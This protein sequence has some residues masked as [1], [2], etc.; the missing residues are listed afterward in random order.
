M[1]GSGSP[2][3]IL[4]TIHGNNSSVDH[5][6]LIP[7][8]VFKAKFSDLLSAL[9]EA[10]RT[11]N[12]KG[13]HDYVV[14]HLKIGSAEC[15]LLERAFPTKK[16]APAS[17]VDALFQCANSIYRSNFG[18]ARRFNGVAEKLQKLLVGVESTFEY[19]ELTVPSAGSITCDA[20]FKSQLDQFV[21]SK[22]ED[23]ALAAKHFRGQAFDSFDCEFLEL[24]FRGRSSRGILVPSGSKVE[25]PCVFD[26]KFPVDEMKGFLKQRVWVVGNAI[27]DG[28][29]QLPARIEV[30]RMRNINQAGRPSDWKGSLRPFELSDWDAGNDVHPKQ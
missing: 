22:D 14:S 7:A 9:K 1:N 24:D 30:A 25:I 18:A 11:V 8:T 21:A 23:A 15:G 12:A 5:E 27:Y 16:E 28:S 4:L 10:D 20:V 3:E 19:M 2:H 6:R 26:S 13:A 17:S 29:R